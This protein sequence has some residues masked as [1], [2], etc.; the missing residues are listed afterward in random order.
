MARTLL[1]TSG[2]QLK[3]AVGTDSPLCGRERPSPEAREHLQDGRLGSQQLPHLPRTGAEPGPPFPPVLPSQRPMSQV[4]AAGPEN[5]TPLTGKPE[6]VT[7]M[8]WPPQLCPPQLQPAGRGGHHIAGSA[9][10]ARALANRALGTRRERAGSSSS[11][12]LDT[13]VPGH[14]VFPPSPQSKKTEAH[15]PWPGREKHRGERSQGHVQ[16]QRLAPSEPGRPALRALPG[17]EAPGTPGW[18]GLARYV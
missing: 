14:A 3:V 7:V 8:L 4:P 17:P 10:P 5:A 6:V 12:S 16:A 18:R 15:G 1:A 2:E 13:T 11:T 9:T